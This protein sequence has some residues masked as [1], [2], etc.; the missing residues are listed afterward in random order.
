MHNDLPSD[1]IKTQKAKYPDIQFSLNIRSP[2]HLCGLIDALTLSLL[3]PGVMAPPD[4]VAS[5]G[6]FGGSDCNTIQSAGNFSGSSL[7]PLCLFSD[8]G[9]SVKIWMGS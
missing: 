6:D 7:S 4:P 5:P 9:L 2:A 1:K 3:R 8:A